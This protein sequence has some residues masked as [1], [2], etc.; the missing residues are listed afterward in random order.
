MIKKAL[1]YLIDLKKPESIT[2]DDLD[3]KDQKYVLVNRPVVDAIGLKSLS[4]LVDY[5]HGPDGIKKDDAVIIADWNIVTLYSRIINPTRQRETI[6]ESRAEAKQFDFGIWKN[7]AEFIIGLQ[8]L[9]QRNADWEKVITIV[10]SVTSVKELTADDNGVNQN[11][12][13]KA[14]IQR[15]GEGSIGDRYTLTANRTFSEVQQPTT[16]FVLRLREKEGE[17]I[18]AALFEADNGVW[19]QDC[20][21]NVKDYLKQKLP[22]FTVIA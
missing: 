6:A 8:S 2:I 5:I 14:G 3:Y 19:E 15:K 13:F 4:G 20:R 7:S 10:S 11:V 21:L 17:G 1:E 18:Q 12:Q 22:D 16:E 9:F